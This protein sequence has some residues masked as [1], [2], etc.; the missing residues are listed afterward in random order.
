VAATATAEGG[1]TYDKVVTRAKE[2]WKKVQ[3]LLEGKRLA[4]E[5]NL[6]KVVVQDREHDQDTE[7]G[8]GK[9]TGGEGGGDENGQCGHVRQ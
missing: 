5:G 3:I 2:G 6:G 8:E 4:R 9:E 7:R 1:P